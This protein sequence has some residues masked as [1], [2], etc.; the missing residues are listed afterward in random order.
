[1]ARLAFLLALFSTLVF[2]ES[3]K[4][5]YN[6][7]A[8]SAQIQDIITAMLDEHLL[9]ESL[10]AQLDYNNITLDKNTKEQLVSI[11]KETLK[12]AKVDFEKYIFSAYE[13]YFSQDDLLELMAFYDTEIGKKLSQFN[14]FINKN[15]VIESENILKHYFPKMTE[16]IE[17][18]LES[19]K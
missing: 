1:M 3:Y 2:A 18:L 5:A 14:V 11:I 13:E 15:S 9:M 4:D 8:E 17:K 12:D 6:K 10:E 7:F 16:K 19:T